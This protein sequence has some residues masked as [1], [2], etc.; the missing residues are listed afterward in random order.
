MGILNKEIIQELIKLNGRKRC[1]VKNEIRKLKSEN[2]R[3]FKLIRF[4]DKDFSNFKNIFD[5]EILLYEE[6]LEELMCTKELFYISITK[7]IEK[8]NHYKEILNLK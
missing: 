7:N 2:K 8:I 6:L 3:T 4:C 1:K 5:D